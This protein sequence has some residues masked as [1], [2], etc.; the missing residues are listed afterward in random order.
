VAVGTI[1]EFLGLNELAGVR[2]QRPEGEA[3]TQYLRYGRL[4]VAAMLIPA[5]RVRGIS[6]CPRVLLDH[7]HA[8]MRRHVE[9]GHTPGFVTLVH[10]RGREH[11]DATGTMA[12]NGTAPTRRDTIFRLASMTKPVTAV[13]AMVLV[14]ECKVRLDD[15][16]DEWLP[17]L[18]DRGSCEARGGR[19]ARPPA[20]EAGAGGLVST[21]DDRA[22][23]GQMMR[24]EDAHGSERILSRP[25]IEL[26]TMDDLTPEHK[27]ASP[28]FANFWNDHGW[29][30]GLGVLTGRSDFPACPDASV[31]TAPSERPG[32]STRR[33]RWLVFS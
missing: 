24:N 23:L 14:E 20:F 11:V 13:G 33:K 16:A 27:A 19:V 6:G 10:H 12:F 28:F 26:M 30:F 2:G 15:P 8:A 5:G 22:A 17:E 18:K 31:G 32:G 9:S 21:I 29:G 25:S 3:A 7:M 1:G 4:F